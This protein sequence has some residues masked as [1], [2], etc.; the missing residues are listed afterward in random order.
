MPF[1]LIVYYQR[2]PVKLM[3]TS[4]L[5]PSVKEGLTFHRGCWGISH[6]TRLFHAHQTRCGR[7]L[8][9]RRSSCCD[10]HCIP[11]VARKW[12][13]YQHLQVYFT[14]VASLI[15]QFHKYRHPQRPFVNQLGVQHK[16]ASVLYVFEHKTW[17]I[18]IHA[19]HTHTVA[20]WHISNIPQGFH[21]SKIC[22]KYPHTL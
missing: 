20:F 12:R 14:I 2:R 13:L 1:N 16:S 21:K 18:L 5:F 19:S 17:Y 10:L 9:D 6:L 7:G 3:F 8:R 4:L 22:Y 15:S 11:F